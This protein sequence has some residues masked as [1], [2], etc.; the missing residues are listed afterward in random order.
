MVNNN[1]Y[2]YYEVVSNN[3]KTQKAKNNNYLLVYNSIPNKRKHCIIIKIYFKD[4][5][6]TYF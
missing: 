5:L 1:F 3:I 4:I 6:K 2:G